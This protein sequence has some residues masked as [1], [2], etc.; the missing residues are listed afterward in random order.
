M[1][2][3]LEAVTN[4]KDGRV[5]VVQ[6][7]VGEPGRGFI[8]NR[9][10]AAGKNQAFRISRANFFGGRIERK[11]FA[12]NSGFTNAARDQLSVLSAEVKYDYSFVS[13][14]PQKKKTPAMTCTSNVAEVLRN[15]NYSVRL[16]NRQRPVSLRVPL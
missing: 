10:R 16:V 14:L 4:A 2:D 7:I 8:V 9:R 11:D 13:R 1:R 5:A 6:Q 12:V 3:Q 15:A